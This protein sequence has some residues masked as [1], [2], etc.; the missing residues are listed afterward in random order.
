LNPE[1][2]NRFPVIHWKGISKDDRHNA[3]FKIEEIT[4]KFG[5]IT[6]FRM[7]SDLEISF[8]IEIGISKVNQLYTELSTCLNLNENNKELP[9]NLNKECLILLQVTFV[10]GKGNL[11]I[12]VP[13]VPG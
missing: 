3:I 11:K 1:L 12:E 5:S 4:N 13:N 9:S 10:K 2:S 8:K 7:F 6:D